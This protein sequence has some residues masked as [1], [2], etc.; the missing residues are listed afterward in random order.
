MITTDRDAD[1]TFDEYLQVCERITV[2][3][4]SVILVYQSLITTTTCNTQ[5]GLAVQS[6]RSGT[7]QSLTQLVVVTDNLTY[8]IESAVLP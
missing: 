6:F 3:R 4:K 1:L 7:R 5:D 8:E 2:V